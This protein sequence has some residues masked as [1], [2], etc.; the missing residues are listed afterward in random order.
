VTENWQTDG[1]LVTL[2]ALFLVGL[3]ADM[4]GR[5]TRLP[6]VT[7]LLICGLAVGK[8]GFDLIP[9]EVRA[10]YDVV[11]VVALTMVAFLLGGDLRLPALRAHGPAILVISL[12]VVIG[13]FA[14][15]TLGLWAVGVPLAAALV[16][17][18]I[19]TAT[20]PAATLDVIRQTGTRGAFAE[21]I[22][23]IVAID[24]GWGLL[25]F[26]LA[27]VAA[28][29]IG[30]ASAGEDTGHG[31][32]ALREIAL[33]IGLGTALGVPA[34]YLTGRLKK[35]EPQRMEALGVVFL[36]AGLALLLDLSYLMAGMTAGILVANLAKH[37]T[38]AF[39]EL[40]SFQWPFMVIF[41]ILAGAT[42]DLAALWI[43]GP[44]GAVFVLARVGGRIIGGWGGSALSG[45]PRAVRPLYGA[46]L[47]PQAGVAIGMAL[48]AV[49]SLPD[50]RNI[51]LP[52]TIGATILFEIVGPV[53]TG[54][55]IARA[56]RHE[57]AKTLSGTSGNSV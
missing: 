10:L 33:S 18:A 54:W 29:G 50:M 14:A 12:S 46:A 41:F 13:T 30:A 2:G 56:D 23:G 43:I 25:V 5:R 3:A 21:R 36:T 39:H 32:A 24:D 35:G 55:A 1:I 8:S 51:I 47:M 20:D 17:G 49:A 34:A 57:D 26:S 52:V 28:Q 38:V 45:D 19:A 16:L 42:A 44:V 11:A 27:L 31:L 22:K 53:L 9:A 6:R 48:V 15:V 37:H 4:L 7:L 40:E